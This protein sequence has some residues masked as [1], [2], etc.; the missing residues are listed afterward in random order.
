MCSRRF[1]S[2]NCISF[3]QQK[4][5]AAS[6]NQESFFRLLPLS[7]YQLPQQFPVP[8]PPILMSRLYVCMCVKLQPLQHT[9]RSVAA[10]VYILGKNGYKY[11]NF[12][13]SGRPNKMMILFASPKFLSYLIYIHIL[14]FT[15]QDMYSRFHRKQTSSSFTTIY[16]HHI[17]KDS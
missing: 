8:T 1:G 4:H 12:K 16:Y 11:G 10:P 15:P 5:T 17:K 9:Y 3:Q 2:L 7:S 14:L 13:S 6:H